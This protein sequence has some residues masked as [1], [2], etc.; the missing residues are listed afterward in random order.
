[1]GNFQDFIFCHR[2]RILCVSILM[3]LVS[4]STHLIFMAE[5]D[6]T[7]SGKQTEAAPARVLEEIRVGVAINAR[8]TGAESKSRKPMSW[9]CKCGR[10]LQASNAVSL[11]SMG[12]DH[13]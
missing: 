12:I 10:S 5:G 4:S 2:N 13:Q 3:F 1:M 6:R 7:V 8:Q 9:K 11:D